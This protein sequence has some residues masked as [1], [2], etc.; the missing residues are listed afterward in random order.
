MNQR[1]EIVTDSF[2]TLMAE[3]GNLTGQRRR[4]NHSTLGT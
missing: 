2:S 3:E 1:K 4:K